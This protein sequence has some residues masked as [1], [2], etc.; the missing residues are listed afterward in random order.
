MER[1]SQWYASLPPCGMERCMTVVYIW[2]ERTNTTSS[3]HL[4]QT[5]IIALVLDIVPLP[6]GTF[7]PSLECEKEVNVEEIRRDL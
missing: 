1:L 2:D 7:P 5:A 4:S 3:F 6:S